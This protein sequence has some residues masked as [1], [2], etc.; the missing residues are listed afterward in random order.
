MTEVAA[1]TAYYL[2]LSPPML[3]LV[4]KGMRFPTGNWLRVADHAA[5]AW[6]VEQLVREL[7]P[8]L[9]NAPLP[10]CVLLTAF[11]VDEFEREMAKAG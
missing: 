2:N 11:D 5:A 8:G 7:F 9:Q 10:F 4:G 3:A 1:D 6:Q